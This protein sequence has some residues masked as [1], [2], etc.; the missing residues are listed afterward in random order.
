MNFLLQTMAIQI[1]SQESLVNF[2]NRHLRNF[3]MINTFYFTIKEIVL[4]RLFEKYIFNTFQ[5][6]RDFA[7]LKCL[8]LSISILNNPRLIF[9]EDT[10]NQ[11]ILTCPTE[12]WKGK[13]KNEFDNY[14]LNA[15]IELK[16]LFRL[17]QLIFK[18]LESSHVYRIFHSDMISQTEHI[19][20]LLSE[21]Y[22]EIH[23]KI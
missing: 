23:T 15:P 14:K 7:Y 9:S 22:V 5:Y 19:K 1:V 8:N 17:K 10:V 20:N 16:R 3:A 6:E 2:T 11:L 18:Y 4:N 13:I 21:I 12:I